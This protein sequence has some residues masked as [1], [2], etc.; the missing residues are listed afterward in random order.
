MEIVIKKIFYSGEV[1][2]SG[3]I[4]YKKERQFQTHENNNKFARIPVI[5]CSKYCGHL[6]AL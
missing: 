6:A 1:Q 2:N 3:D 5:H 4:L